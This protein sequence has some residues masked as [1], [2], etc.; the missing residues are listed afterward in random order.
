M[1]C[2]WKSCEKKS[3]Y[4]GEKQL[5]T[6]RRVECK[7]IITVHVQKTSIT[8]ND[9]DNTTG[10]KEKT[11][12]R[13]SWP[14]YI[15]IYILPV[16]VA[17]T[18]FDCTSMNNMTKLSDLLIILLLLNF[19]GWEEPDLVLKHLATDGEYT[20]QN[21]W[22]FVL[23]KIKCFIQTTIKVKSLLHSVWIALMFLGWF[24]F[25]RNGKTWTWCGNPVSSGGWRKSGFPPKMCGNRMCCFIIGE[26][27]CTGTA[28]RGRLLK[29]YKLSRNQFKELHRTYNKRESPMVTVFF[30]CLQCW[31]WLWRHLP[32][33]HHR[34]PPRQR[35]VD[36]SRNV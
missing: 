28:V 16:S 18:S 11:C 23:Q 2:I 10:T 3:E 13:L 9:I 31:R 34:K 5:L 33:Q 22:S 15:L 21:I 24:F 35:Q 29:R 19:L 6:D 20:L 26:H 36:P 25:F 14:V 12:Q 7:F 8:C 30:F 32:L 4:C 27:D 17:Q 1:Y